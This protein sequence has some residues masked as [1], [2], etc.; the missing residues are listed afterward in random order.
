M[1]D[2]IVLV[3]EIAFLFTFD[4]LLCVLS[5]RQHFSCDNCCLCPIQEIK[6]KLYISEFL[7][8][9]LHSTNNTKWK[10]KI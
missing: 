3:L 1:W 6:S 5:C 2:L 8:M 7:T 9:Y 4:T 10:V